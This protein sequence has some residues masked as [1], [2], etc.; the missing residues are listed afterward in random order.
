MIAELKDVAN[1][2]ITAYNTYLE[3]KEL[4]RG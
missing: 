2:F 3:V 1:R 4:F